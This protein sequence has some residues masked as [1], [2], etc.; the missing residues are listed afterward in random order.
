MAPLRLTI[1]KAYASPAKTP[2]NR[3]P[4]TRLPATAIPRFL[5]FASHRQA[6]YQSALCKRRTRGSRMNFRLVRHAILVVRL[7][8]KTLLVDP[9]L[10]P[11]GAMPPISNSPNDRRN[12][13]VRLP[14]L[15]LSPVDAV[16]V[17]HTPGPLRRSRS[18]KAAQSSA[19]LLPARGRREAPFLRLLRRSLLIRAPAW[20]NIELLRTGGQH[21]TGRSGRRWPVSGFVLRAPGEP[22]LYIAGDT[23]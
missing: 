14:D 11:P 22:A 16:V 4:A 7:G 6:Y 20:E 5:C 8:G 13:L 18:R 17:T 21:G 19:A 2:V 12:P 1:P 15:D 23:I 3:R 9:M 10:S